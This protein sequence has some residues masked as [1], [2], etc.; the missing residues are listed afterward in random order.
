MIIET[1]GVRWSVAMRRLLLVAVMCG[2]VTAA[3]AADLSDLPILR[4]S[5]SDG[6]S[7]GSVNWAG[8][9]VG[10]QVTHG[11]ADMNFTNSGQDLLAKLLNNVD[12]EAQF[13]ISKWPLLSTTHMQSSGYG[14]FIGYNFQWSDAIVGIE[15]NYTHGNFFGASSGS[16]SRVFSY[17]TDYLST[18]AVSSSSSMRIT[19]YGSLRVRGA[20]AVDC[21]LP[22]AFVGMALGQ[23]NI[24]RRADTYLYYQYV[25][26]A[27]PRLPNIGP[28]TD[29]L[30][31]NANSH[32]ISGLAAGL[33]IDVM[34]Y[35]GLFLRAEWEYL[36]F[37]SSD[38]TTVDAN[39]NTVRAGLG[40]KF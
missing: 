1:V 17:P 2:A 10:G 11:S 14:G 26:S 37:S 4:G 12:L 36:R 19:D 22:Y 6:L 25:G 8:V 15:L 33:G 23:A 27:I 9:Y 20:Y 13:D 29:S 35:A 21:F 24:N 5:F 28:A 30:T 32:F 40:Y 7:R 39:I 16:Q 18:A 31:D 3:Q 38:N 34:L